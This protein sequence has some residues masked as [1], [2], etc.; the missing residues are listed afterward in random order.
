MI[1]HITWVKSK[2]KT[3]FHDA[4]IGLNT[5]IGWHWIMSTKISSWLP[6]TPEKTNKWKH[7]EQAYKS[8]DKNIEK[9]INVVHN[10]NWTSN[11]QN[12]FKIGALCYSSILKVLYCVSGTIYMHYKPGDPVHFSSYWILSS[13]YDT[14]P[15]AC[16]IWKINWYFHHQ[17]Q[18]CTTFSAK[19]CRLMMMPHLLVYCYPEC[20]TISYSNNFHIGHRYKVLW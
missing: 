18:N 1:Y 20:C 2:T 15:F 16:L 4:S 11:K 9:I 14:W 5:E 17:V 6:Q 10:Y 8:E 19:T 13:M 12:T 7:S 3:L